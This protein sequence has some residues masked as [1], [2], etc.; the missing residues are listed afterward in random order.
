MK[1]SSILGSLLLACCIALSVQTSFIKSMNGYPSLT[2]V[3]LYIDSGLVSTFTNPGYT[4]Y[5]SITGGSHQVTLKDAS[6]NIIISVTQSFPD[7]GHYT[8]FITNSAPFL[9]FYTDDSSI[10]RTRF[11]HAAPNFTPR[12]LYIRLTGVPESK[13]YTGLTYGTM[14]EYNICNCNFPNR[15]FCYK[16]GFTRFPDFVVPSVLTTIVDS[17][18]FNDGAGQQYFVQQ[19]SF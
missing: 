8:I 13:I 10:A 3:S 9:S 2:T 12:D 14:F 6:G 5:S 18:V 15:K 7:G 17:M 16:D 19:N 11:W 1:I 4:S